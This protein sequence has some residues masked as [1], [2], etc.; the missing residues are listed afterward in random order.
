L[1]KARGGLF[2][3]NLRIASISTKKTANSRAT[4]D[5]ICRTL[6]NYN[7]LDLNRLKI[8]KFRGQEVAHQFTARKLSS[9]F[10]MSPEELAT[11]YHLPTER[12]APNLLHVVSHREPPPR[13]LPTQ[14]NDPDIS[15]FGHT[16]FR[17]QKIPFGIK[18]IDRRRHLYCIGK[19]GV[20]KSKLLELLIKSDIE[21]GHGVGVL[22]PHGDLVDNILD[23][24]P[25]HR[26]KDVVLFDPSDLN[27]PPAFNPLE[28]VGDEYKTRVTIGFIEI[29]KK[30]FGDS[31]TPRLEHVLRYTTLALLDSPN[32]TVLSIMKMLNDKDYR[33]G[34]VRNIDDKV[35]RN[36]WTSEFAG[37]SEK[38]DNEAITPLLNKVGQFVSTNM[39]RNIVGYEDLQRTS[40]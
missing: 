28:N 20:G 38:Y 7:T 11:V 12:V 24:I 32:T 1:V 18:R 23:F 3:A 29:F 25:E 22:D 17:G 39:I 6:K 15:F 5:S 4:L 27:F 19:S 30:L 26:I 33:Q 13:E 37:W 16:N 35:V 10:L 34:I 21:Q 9:A 40:G 14:R 2:K 8:G 31:W 36:F